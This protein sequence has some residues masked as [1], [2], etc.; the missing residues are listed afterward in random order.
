M[1]SHPQPAQPGKLVMGVFLKDKTL[2][3]PVVHDLSAAFGT[4]EMVSPWFDFNYTNYYQKEM[5]APLFR[6][7]LVFQ[8]LIEQERLAD[9][10]LRTNALEAAF[11][12]KSR[13]TVNIDPGYIL[14][15][16]FVLATGKNFSHRIYIGH[17]IYADLTLIYRE[18]DFQPLPWTYPDYASAPMRRFLI[19]VRTKYARDMKQRFVPGTH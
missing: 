6:R 5:G 11:S 3:D 10:K 1:M 4:I 15:E 12:Q 18:K 16:R 7:M 19:L 14:Y 8:E 13:R 9:C 2:M 17:G